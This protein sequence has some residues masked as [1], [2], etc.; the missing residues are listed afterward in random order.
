MTCFRV[1][2]LW[3]RP[4]LCQPCL[5]PI[6]SVCIYVFDFPQQEV[7]LQTCSFFKMVTE[8][9]SFSILYARFPA[10]PLLLPYMSHCLMQLRSFTEIVR[11]ILL[12]FFD[13]SAR[14]HKRHKLHF[15]LLFSLKPS[16][17]Q[18]TLQKA[19]VVYNRIIIH[20]WV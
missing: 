7:T 15:S 4:T 8:S 3:V 1:K 14:Q 20:S 17:S 13:I 12:L 6:P 10:F 16:L 11:Q 19:Y 18:I 2:F 9:T 5:F